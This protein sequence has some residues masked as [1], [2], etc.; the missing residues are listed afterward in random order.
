MTTD[1]FDDDQL[2]ALPVEPEP[3]EER[4]RLGSFET[5][6]VESED[7]SAEAKARAAEELRPSPLAQLL[8]G[9][10]AGWWVWDVQAQGGVREVDGE[11]RETRERWC[12][13]LRPG[14]VAAT[15]FE[16]R[17]LW[18][19][20]FHSSG[21]FGCFCAWGEAPG[22][23]FQVVTGYA[24]PSAITPGE[25]RGAATECVLTETGTWYATLT[26]RATPLA[27]VEI[28]G[29]GSGPPEDQ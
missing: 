27:F 17:V 10:E 13:W 14:R 22:R 12:L 6:C 25:M 2:D 8:I 20:G 11:V 9:A 7:L 15:D 29:E 1:G 26:F 4:L 5:P 18:D 3:Q 24:E 23:N 21:R 28:P 16:G 19:G